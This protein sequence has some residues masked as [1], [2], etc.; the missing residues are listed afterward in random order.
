MLDSV[1]RILED[2]ANQSLE[3]LQE[4]IREYAYH[5]DPL[6]TSGSNVAYY[7]KTG[8]PTGQFLESWYIDDIKYTANEMITKIFY[9]GSAMDFDPDTYLHGSN[10]GG[11]ARE[12]L[13]DILNSPKAEFGGHTSSWYWKFVH[14][15]Y[16]DMFIQKM[17]KEKELDNIFKRAIAKEAAF[18][19]V[20]ITRR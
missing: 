9:D 15:P 6:T 3:I 2:A 1:R 19:G 16:W 14:P 11:D 10:A 7:N 20:R 4:Y 17:F 13:A 12:S 8:T 5:Y 18:S